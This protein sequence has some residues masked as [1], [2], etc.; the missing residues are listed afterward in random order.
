[1]DL[2]RRQFMVAAG[3]GVS[4]L[5]MPRASQADNEVKTPSNILPVDHYIHPELATDS[6][7]PVGICWVLC[8]DN[9][10][11]VDKREYQAQLDASAETIR[12]SD[13]RETIFYKG[14]PGSGEDGPGSAALFI[15]DFGSDSKLLLPGIDFR[16]NDPAKFERVADIIQFEIGRR[17]EASSTFHHVGLYNASVCFDEMKK[18]WQCDN[19]HVLLK[20]D[21]T[22]NIEEN[23]RAGKILAERHGANVSSLVTRTGNNSSNYDWCKE[24]LSTPAD[25]YRGP[26]GLFVPAGIT[27]EVAT[28]AE[29]A[30][31][32]VTRYHDNVF[33]VFRRQLALH[34][35]NNRHHKP[36]T[37]F[38]QFG[39]N[40][41][42]VL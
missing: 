32:N 19:N 17:M 3:A 23:K 27:T 12:N 6:N 36:R 38:A 25:T 37:Q 26:N 13:F 22:G 39:L 8:L 18:R 41:P 14:S 29:T 34:F 4:S 40:E 10:S 30:G 1:M 5:I 24:H 42:T 15:V 2:S 9:S 35:A 21:G 7:D 11:S 31:Q 20:T 16:E 33:G 28:E